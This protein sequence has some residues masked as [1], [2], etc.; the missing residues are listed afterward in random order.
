MR[1]L[2]LS[3][4]LLAPVAFGSMVLP[5]GKTGT[6]LRQGQDYALFFPVSN[7]SHAN[8]TNLDQ[9]VPN[10]QAIARE[11]ETSFGFTTEIVA[12]ATYG[13][14]VAKLQEYSQKFANGQLPADGQLFLYF[15][16]HGM[17]EFNSG[18]FLP[19][20]A[21]P[22]SLFNS[23]LGYSYWRQFISNI[24]CQHIMVAV[25]ACYS[26]T[27]DP[28]H[29]F[30]NFEKFGRKG[31]LTEAQRVLANHQQ[32]KS[33]IF[34]TSDSKEDKTPGRSNFARKLLQGLRE[35][36]TPDG[37]VTSSRLFSN[38]VELAQPAPR[39]ADFE[40]D[41]PSATFLFFHEV[42]RDVVNEQNDLA[43]WQATQQENDCAAYREYLRQFPYGDF[44]TTARQRVAPCEAEERMLAAWQNAKARNDCDA[45]E[46]FAGDYPRSA[47]AGLV[48]E[49]LNALNCSMVN[50]SEG[51][52]PHTGY[53]GNV[54]GTVTDEDG[55]PLIGAKIVL[56][57]TSA[58]ILTDNNGFFSLSVK[59]KFTPELLVS[60]TEFQDKRIKLDDFR[61]GKNLKLDKIS[62]VGKEY[63]YN[64][65][66]S[67]IVTDKKGNL[68]I[69]ASIQLV[70]TDTLE[71]TDLDGEFHLRVKTDIVPELV[72][73]YAGFQDE[74]IKL[75]TSSKYLSVVLMK[76]KRGFWIKN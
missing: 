39:A 64:I 54:S 48:P 44:A 19:A 46:Q 32:Y 36:R 12:N 45:Y 49:R 56:V 21:N 17:R 11:L 13:Q 67:G 20:D 41:D 22:K 38:Y 25:D 29:T 52:S 59:T 14:I 57:G 34:F 5:E 4:L 28:D 76:K 70:G 69:G 73:S 2:T 7:Y 24:N 75:T 40:G 23:G 37:F 16:G 31:E 65:D 62:L 61:I 26:V 10:A 68:L 53:Y 1:I 27:F 8:L 66:M 74:K 58:R 47:Y 30:A 63:V 50:A 43:A 42:R 55:E 72:V 15:S 3:L 9:A 60:Y 18:Y 71:N 33:R 6:V 35:L 51:N